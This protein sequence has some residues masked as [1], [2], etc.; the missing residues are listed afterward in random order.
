MD[1]EAIAQDLNVV[2]SRAQELLNAPEPEA[3]YFYI[4][5]IDLETPCL[6]YPGAKG[7][8][9]KAFVGLDNFLGVGYPGYE[10]IP[11][12]QRSTLRQ[13]QIPVE[14][15]HAILATMGLENFNDP[16]LL[17]QMI[18]H[19]KIGVASDALTGYGL[20]PAEILGYLPQE[21]AFLEENERNIW[22]VL[23]REQLLFSTDPLVRQRLIEPAP[24][25]KF[26][27]AQ[28][29]EIP[30]RAA[31]FIGYQLVKS[32]AEH[33]PELGLKELLKIRDAQK[34][35]RDAQYKP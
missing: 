34:F 31:R 8:P 33:H 18:Y 1:K 17:G 6:F 13:S 2:S 25:S 24:F 23:V 22:E 30:G 19:G 16:T 27:T 10:F 15:A 4:S 21:W 26:G 28:D 7:D 9:S 29:T 32:Y 11:A 3:L 12:Y 14:Y 5:G 20:E 35:L